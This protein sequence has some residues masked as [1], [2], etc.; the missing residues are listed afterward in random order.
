ME[1]P[2][3]GGGP[4]IFHDVTVIR[5][6]SAEDNGF[7]LKDR[8][9]EDGVYVCLRGPMDVEGGLHCIAQIAQM[10]TDPKGDSMVSGGQ[11]G[12]PDLGIGSVI[13]LTVNIRIPVIL[14][15]GPPGSPLPFKSDIVSVQS[16]V[17]RYEI[18]VGREEVEDVQEGIRPAVQGPVVPVRG[19]R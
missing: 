11:L 6:V 17:R 19:G 5:S 12:H 14:H 2:V 9:G 10:V 4:F 1:D 16:G 8:G 3:Q 15:D 13:Q 7:P 18:D